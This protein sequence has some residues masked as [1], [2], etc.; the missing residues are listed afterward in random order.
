MPSNP[1]LPFITQQWGPY[2]LATSDDFSS[3]GG[4]VLNVARGCVRDATGWWDAVS[5]YVFNG[6]RW[7]PSGLASTD[8]WLVAFEVTKLQDGT[9]QP[10]RGPNVNVINNSTFKL[11][12]NSNLVRIG[13]SGQAVSLTSKA[14]PT[15]ISYCLCRY[16]GRTRTIQWLDENFNAIC[17]EYELPKH[18]VSASAPYNTFWSIGSDHA[19]RSI[20]VYK[21]DLSQTLL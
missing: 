17:D 3:S 20:A 8:D 16:N 4:P 2:D 6:S 1:F 19:I 10:S 15:L 11:G 18:S 5:D 13:I 7:L 21:L 9:A 12:L 14:T